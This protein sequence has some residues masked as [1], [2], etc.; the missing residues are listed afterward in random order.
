LAPSSASMTPKPTLLLNF[1]IR[2]CTTHSLSLVR[3]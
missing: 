3:P 2:P 1:V